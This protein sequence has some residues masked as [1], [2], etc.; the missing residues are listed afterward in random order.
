[1]TFQ[2][3]A[4][5]PEGQ[6]TVFVESES[7]FKCLDLAR[8]YFRKAFGEDVDLSWKEVNS[9]WWGENVPDTYAELEYTSEQLE[10]D[11]I[12]IEG[13]KWDDMNYRHLTER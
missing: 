7:K 4:T 9:G 12:A 2:V 11:P 10:S 1:M 3:T 13:A 6:L 8:H 5:L